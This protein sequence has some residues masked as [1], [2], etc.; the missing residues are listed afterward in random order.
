MST[1]SY[2]TCRTHAQASVARLE[3]EKLTEHEATIVR[4]ELFEAA[5]NAAWRLVVDCSPVTLIASV[6]LGVLA[7][8]SSECKKNGGRLVITGLSDQLLQVLHVTRLDKLL[9]IAPDVDAAAAA[10]RK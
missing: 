10:A 5:E 8:L 6:G 7:N 9:A 2:V 3:R 1:S 4:A